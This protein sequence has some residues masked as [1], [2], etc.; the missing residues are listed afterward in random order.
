MT[1][2]SN[3]ETPKSASDFLDSIAAS[4]FNKID[5]NGGTGDVDNGVVSEE[6]I[7]SKHEEDKTL[8]HIGEENNDRIH[9]NDDIS[10]SDIPA[11]NEDS[12]KEE[13]SPLKKIKLEEDHPFHNQ[14]VVQEIR[15]NEDFE[16]TLK[17][18]RNNGFS[19]VNH[20]IED[21]LRSNP[22]SALQGEVSSI[23][24]QSEEPFTTS[25]AHEIN[26][27]NVNKNAH[28]V[29]TVHTSQGDD[30]IKADPSVPMKHENLNTH[31]IHDT[32]IPQTSFSSSTADLEKVT[33][34]SSIANDYVPQPNV[35][36]TVAANSSIP[37]PRNALP[38]QSFPKERRLVLLYDKPRYYHIIMQLKE[39]REMPDNLVT[40]VELCD[41]D[42]LLNDKILS[43]IKFDHLNICIEYNDE[44]E[45]NLKRFIDFFEKHP[46][47]IQ[48]VGDIGYH[49]H[50]AP[51]KKW[52][53]YKEFEVKEYIRFLQI[54]HKVAGDKVVHCSVINKYDMDTVYITER[55][56]LAKLGQEIQEDIENWK[57]LKVLDYG[58]SSI[59]FLPGVKLPDSLEVLNIGG[60]YAL[61]TLTGFK[62]PPK[63]RTLLAGQGAVHS[64]DNI[65]FP[66]TLENLG[67]E[68]NKIYFLNYVEF[69]ETLKHLDVSQNRIESLRGV[70]FPKGLISLNLGFNPIDSIKSVKFPESLQY[71]EVSNIPNESMTG[72]KFPDHLDVLNLQSSMTTT[73]GLKLP[74]YVKTLILAG[75][76]VNSINP[77]KLP[78]SVE[79]LYLNDNNI[80]TL[81]KVQFPTN[82]RELY[83]GDN[84]ITTLKNVTL[85]PTLEVLD[86]ENDPDTE[87]HDKF[88]T[89]L[90]D[91]VF[92]PNL[93][94]LKLGYHAIKIIEAVDFPYSLTSLGLSYN[95]LKLIRGVRFGNNLKLLDLSGNHELT[96]ID[97]LILPESL[98]ELRVPPELVPNLPAYIIERANKKQLLIKKSIPFSEAS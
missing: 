57:N 49:I 42:S 30:T 24:K 21:S 15:H 2:S 75:N 82:L 11:I 36:T 60:G 48:E 5:E 41:I 59:R 45:H 27:V 80:K 61:E 1:S 77:L 79:I 20:T 47:K 28:F 76:G 34:K 14:N 56:E 87:E 8:N 46:E 94:V 35:P 39:L 50:F 44:F 52:K 38:Q 29:Q 62:M 58:E 32:P 91:V 78:N 67:L 68:D 88:I 85:P 96:S 6:M 33:N 54:L 37:P 19:D 25:D 73:R 31:Q 95:D 4:S 72:V 13:G 70:N 74:P 89:T 17:H 23:V 7:F 12:H 97:N 43:T 71:L 26:E 66:S 3:E 64:I 84:M 93:K 51:G 10:S 18:E 92:P 55:N 65:V 83:L 63:L 9:H 53:D 90:K 40:V 22:T 16:S 86:F 81:N 69:P 98:S